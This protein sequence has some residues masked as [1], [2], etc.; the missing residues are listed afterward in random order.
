MSDGRKHGLH[1]LMKR[2][3]SL[4]NDANCVLAHLWR[5]TLFN[6]EVDAP[7]WEALLENYT[8]NLS[9]EIGEKKAVNRKGNIPKKLAGPQIT[10]ERFAQGVSVFNFEEVA[11]TLVLTEGGVDHNFSVRIPLIYGQDPGEILRL[12]W[13]MI[14][15][16]FPEKSGKGWAR[17]AEDYARKYLEEN[18]EVPGYLKGNNKRALAKPSLMWNM[19]Y[20]GLRIHGYERIRIELA[21]KP[22]GRDFIITSLELGPKD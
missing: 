16:R 20:R 10:W 11:F 13:D 7:L 9:R 6:L 2:D 1:Q 21:T 14:N 19:F 3:A 22:R 4:I 17:L 5:L 12:L 18:G 8:F 15:K